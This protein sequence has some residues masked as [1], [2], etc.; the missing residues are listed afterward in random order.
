M[1]IGRVG[2]MLRAVAGSRLGHIFCVL[3]LI[4]LLLFF[5]SQDPVPRDLNNDQVSKYSSSVLM[6]GRGFHYHYE[7]VELKILILLDAPGILLSVFLSLLLLPVA[8]LLP[9][10]GEYD[11]SWVA[12]AIIFVGTSTQWLLVGYFLERMIRN[13]LR[14]ADSEQ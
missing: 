5:I 3:H 14:S 7:P 1:M 12:A 10:L 2:R 9:P 13:W 8:L 11:G 4:L 6:A